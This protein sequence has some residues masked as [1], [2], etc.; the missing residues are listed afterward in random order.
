MLI[1]HTYFNTE[2][3]NV[4]NTDNPVSR[5]RLTE[6]IA[7]REPM[8]LESLLGYNLYSAFKVAITQPNPE[9][10]FTALRDGSVYT[11]NGKQQRWKGLVTTDPKTSI[12]AFYC[13]YWWSRNNATTTTGIGEMSN[14]KT[15]N[16][17][18]VSAADKQ[19]VVWGMMR[20]W[21]CDL[22]EFL[23]SNAGDYP[24]WDGYM[25][26]ELVT[27]INSFGI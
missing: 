4:P 16:T 9:A 13:W 20:D 5:A 26:F 11:V 17:K 25:N 14:Q 15:D 19:A 22:Y 2:F 10:R 1:D 3:V 12:I 21:A 27:S 8:L 6:L 24:E 18:P 7:I 23:R